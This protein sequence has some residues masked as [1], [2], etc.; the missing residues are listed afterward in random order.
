MMSLRMMSPVTIK[1][2][3][4]PLPIK[5][6]PPLLI[7]R[8]TGTA[9]LLPAGLVG[10]GAELLFLAVAHGADAIWTDSP[11]DQSLLGRVGTVLAQGEVIFR[12]SAVIAIA[13]DDNFEGRMR[14]QEACILSQNSLSVGTDLIAVVIEECRLHVVLQD[15]LIYG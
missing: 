2:R 11:I 10:L 13:P 3:S 6:S 1:E 9:I 5:S 4:K 12:R 14:S 8:E 7:K 15:L